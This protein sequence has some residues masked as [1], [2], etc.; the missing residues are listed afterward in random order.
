MC[1]GITEGQVLES[2]LSYSLCRV[3]SSVSLGHLCLTEGMEGKRE[4]GGG[5]R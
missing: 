5:G 1:S 2:R 3:D 4:R